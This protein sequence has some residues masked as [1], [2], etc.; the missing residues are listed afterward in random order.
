M[1]DDEDDCSQA[2]TLATLPS[3]LGKT[4]MGTKILPIPPSDYITPKAKDTLNLQVIISTPVTVTL[5]L[6]DFLKVKPKLWAQV[7][8]LLRDKGYLGKE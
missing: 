5:P 8:K 7:T 4:K 1:I 2:N 3:Y 6:M